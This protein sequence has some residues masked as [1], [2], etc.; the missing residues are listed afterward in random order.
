VRGD[1]HGDRYCGHKNVSIHAPVWGATDTGIEAD[2]N[3]LFQSTPL[4]EGRPLSL[5][6]IPTS[7][8]V[9]IHAPVWGATVEKKT[10]AQDCVVSIHAPVRGAT[11]QIW[12]YCRW[13]Q[14]SIHA[15]VWGAT[16][17]GCD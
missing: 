11:S 5:S 7:R 3:I 10:E 1:G 4:C 9:S 12:R 17:N 6:A 8:I 13:C 15:P 16:C 14:V 2:L